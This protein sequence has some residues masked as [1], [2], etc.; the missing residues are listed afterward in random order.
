VKL[1]KGLMLLRV[2]FL[3]QVGAI[4][5]LKP[6]ISIFNIIIVFSFLIQIFIDRHVTSKF[7]VKLS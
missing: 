3:T 5:K 6:H 2:L 4:E 1:E 7:T